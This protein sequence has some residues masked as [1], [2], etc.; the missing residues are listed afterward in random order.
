MVLPGEEQVRSVCGGLERR[1]TMTQMDVDTSILEGLDEEWVSPCEFRAHT[2]DAPA[3]WILW[4][5]CCTVGG[6][7]Y[8]LGC[9]ACKDRK[10]NQLTS[11]LCEDCNKVYTPASRAWRLIEPLNRKS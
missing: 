4:P 3:A 7:P 8:A 11:I 2:G 5:T 10:I 9:D 1:L 6:A